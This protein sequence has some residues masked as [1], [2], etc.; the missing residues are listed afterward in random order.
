MGNTTKPRR[1]YLP[2]PVARDPI[3]LAMRRASKIPPQEIAAVMAP[4]KEAFTAMRE[5]VATESQWVILASSVELA[6]Q[7]E[8]QGVVRGVAGHLTAAEAALAA[9]KHRAME[10]G[11]WRPTS[12]Y[13]QEIEAL[14][15]FVPIHKHQLDHLSEGEWREVYARAEAIVRSAGGQVYDVRELQDDA[16]QLQLLEGAQA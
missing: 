2:R 6:L 15:V 5:G 11:A 1:K 14:D 4:I 12:L 9:I 7:V 16:Q 10:R 13:W 3:Q 8:R